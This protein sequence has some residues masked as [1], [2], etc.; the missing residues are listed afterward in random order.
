MDYCFKVDKVPFIAQK[1]NYCGPAALAM[2]MNYFGINVTQEEIANEI[3]APGLKGTLSMQL[4]LYPIQKG[5]EAEMY[6]GN[7]DDL[8]E[9]IKAWFP[10]IV[11]VKE[12]GKDKV[13]YMV[14]WGYDE[15]N[16]RVFVHSGNKMAQAIEYET[17]M[18][19]WKRTDYLTIWV[20]PLNT[21]AKPA[22]GPK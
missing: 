7:F 10:L 8:K 14:V 11:S 20:Y 1:E 15:F 13:H 19:M 9:K 4:V 2:V 12:D 16:K 3:Y 22:F 5:F 17:F 18:D 6:N 21:P